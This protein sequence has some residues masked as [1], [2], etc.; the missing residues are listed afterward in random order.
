MAKINVTLGQCENFFK[1]VLSLNEPPK[2]NTLSP[3]T[4]FVTFRY[5]MVSYLNYVIFN[6]SYFPIH[7]FNIKSSVVLDTKKWFH[8]ILTLLTE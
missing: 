5:E 8:I 7:F 6:M 4:G 1:N 3:C 2:F